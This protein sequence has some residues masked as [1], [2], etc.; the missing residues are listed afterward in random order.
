MSTQVQYPEL[1]N[2]FDKHREVVRMLKAEKKLNDKQISFKAIYYKLGKKIGESKDLSSV[3]AFTNVIIGRYQLNEPDSITVTWVN[4]E[5][6]EKLYEHTFSINLRRKNNSDEQHQEQSNTLQGFNGLGE[7]EIN[8]L[9][10]KRLT[11]LRKNEE[12]DRLK[13]DNYR[14]SQKISELEQSKT[15]LEEIIA[16]KNTSESI[17]R[18]IGLAFPVVAKYM[19]NNKIVNFLAGTDNEEYDEQQQSQ[20]LNLNQNNDRDEMITMI[21]EYMQSDLNEQEVASL[22]LMFMDIQSDKSKIQNIL[23]YISQLK[24]ATTT[25]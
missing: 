13:E 8:H 21:C 14:M 1:R 12:Y 22:Y 23:N 5:N 20:K 24:N 6:E 19:K 7:A 3:S 9:V 15:D 25:Q 4:N 2:V 11:E 18:G 16:A 10:E 17:M